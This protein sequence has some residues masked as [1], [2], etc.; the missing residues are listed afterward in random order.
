L[1]NERSDRRKKA[2]YL[3]G[4]RR[5]REDLAIGNDRFASGHNGKKSIGF[6]H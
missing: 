4:S 5:G 6:D 1:F 3:C 2:S